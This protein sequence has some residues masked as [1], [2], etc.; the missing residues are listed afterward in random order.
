MG[1]MGEIAHNYP[2]KTDM[3]LLLSSFPHLPVLSFFPN[4]HTAKNLI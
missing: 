4:K 3:F 1:V 2:Q